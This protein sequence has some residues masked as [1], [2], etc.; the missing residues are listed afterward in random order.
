MRIANRHTQLDLKVQEVFNMP[1]SLEVADKM[2]EAILAAHLEAKP[3][4]IEALISHGFSEQSAAAIWETE[5][6]VWVSY[7]ARAASV[8][9]LNGGWD[10]GN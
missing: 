2:D 8:R 6:G 5:R 4:C 3:H 7:W 9:R 1:L 10:G